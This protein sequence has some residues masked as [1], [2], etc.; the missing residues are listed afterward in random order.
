MLSIGA[1]SSPLPCIASPAR[2]RGSG[3]WGE[4]EQKAFETPRSC[5]LENNVL[6]AFD[7]KKQVRVRVDASDDGKGW[8]IYQLKDVDG[9]D[10]ADNRAILRYGSKAWDRGMRHRPPYYKEADGL[11]TA[12]TDARYYAEATE[13]PL[14]IFTDHAPLQFIKNAPRNPSRA[15]ASRTSWACSTRSATCRGPKN[16]ES[17]ALSRY[18]MLGPR[19]LNRVG[20][21]NAMDVLLKALP[22]G[23]AATRRISH[24]AVGR[25]RHRALTGEAQGMASEARTYL[26]AGRGASANR[27]GTRRGG[28]RS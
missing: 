20:I 28:S 24:L 15:G 12:A 9:D 5:A 18:P 27:S 16:I 17:D 26:H 13:Y 6:A 19:Q 4:V 8:M 22:A 1:A 11:I 2:C 3:A 10:S 14:I 7:H 21:A 23:A 25:P